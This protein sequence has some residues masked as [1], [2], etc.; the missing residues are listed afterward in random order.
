MYQ[1][2]EQWSETRHLNGGNNF[3]RSVSVMTR[4]TTV[5]TVLLLFS[6]IS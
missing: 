1:K 2:H 3:M 5:S 6:K 4:E